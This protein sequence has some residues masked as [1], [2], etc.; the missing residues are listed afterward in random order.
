MAVEMNCAC[1]P[2]VPGAGC[3]GVPRWHKWD[4]LYF[5]LEEE[6]WVAFAKTNAALFF[7]HF[8]GGIHSDGL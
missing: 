5:W 8:N 7:V 4:S 6:L 2:W 3:M 1:L